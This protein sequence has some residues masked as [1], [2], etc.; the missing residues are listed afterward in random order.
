M[1]RTMCRIS[2]AECSMFIL[3]LY[4]LSLY[5]LA[6]SCALFLH[7]IF[8]LFT[9]ALGS[10]HK[11]LLKKRLYFYIDF[12]ANQNKLDIL[13]YQHGNGILYLFLSVSYQRLQFNSTI[14]WYYS[15]IKESISNICRN[16][17]KWIRINFATQ[18]QI[19]H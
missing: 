1:C 4:S 9:K 6:P 14:Y 18:I 2:R 8:A 12:V 3:L 7:L 10:A 13:D 15:L 19:K 16:Y 17:F 5:L 11:F